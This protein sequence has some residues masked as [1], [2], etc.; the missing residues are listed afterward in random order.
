MVK[1]T[2]QTLPDWTF[3]VHETSA[4]VYRVIAKHSL[5]ASVEISGFGP[6]ELLR[7]AEASAHDMDRD[8]AKKTGT[9]A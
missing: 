7:E 6:D 8:I 1:R 2:V 3:D 4:G 9:R 5:G